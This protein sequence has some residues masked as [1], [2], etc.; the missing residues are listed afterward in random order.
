MREH[1]QEHNYSPCAHQASDSA[2][3]RNVAIYLQVQ[4]EKSAFTEC[5]HFTPQAK[6]KKSMSFTKRYQGGIYK[7]ISEQEL[8]AEEGNPG[9]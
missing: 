9:L 4:E 2:N 3:I 5:V 7:M 1:I 8:I 6:K